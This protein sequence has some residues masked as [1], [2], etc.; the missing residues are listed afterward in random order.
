[1]CVYVYMCIHVY[2]CV[3]FFSLFW[4]NYWLIKISQNSGFEI[5]KA[6]VGQWVGGFFHHY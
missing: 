2:V 5:S 1:M 4:K 6:E 3:Y